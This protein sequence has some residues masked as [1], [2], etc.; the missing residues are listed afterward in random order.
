MLDFNHPLAGK[1][2]TFEIEVVSAEG[3]QIANWN[4]KMK[5]AELFEIAKSQG[6]SVNT[7]STKAQIIEA[8]SA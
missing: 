5:K 6:L 7:R 8:L 4:T 1:E 2:L 3:V